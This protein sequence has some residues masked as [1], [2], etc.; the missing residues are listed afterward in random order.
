MIIKDQDA[1]LKDL[2]TIH[3]DIRIVS[4]KL[5]IVAD[6]VRFKCRYGCRAYG[7]HLCCPPY[8]PTPEETRRV[9]SEYNYAVLVRFEAKPN[10]DLMPEHTHH[11]LWDSLTRMHRIIYELEKRAFLGGY[12]KAFGMG[13]LPCT[14]C[15]ICIAEEKLEKNE[16]IHLLDSLKC[17]HKDIMRPSMEACGIDVFKTLENAGYNLTILKDYAE[18]LVL[19]GM[20]L[21]D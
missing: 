14:L 18:R 17:R 7:K 2:Q 4:T 9:I 1:V 15:D 16:T 19:F 13:A 20:I 6:W 12:Y 11:A 5:V 3:P 10:K 21:L 8:A